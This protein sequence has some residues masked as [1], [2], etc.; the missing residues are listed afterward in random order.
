MV[1]TE[2]KQLCLVVNPEIY[3]K[4]FGF[5]KKENQPSKIRPP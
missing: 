2:A 3:K 1:P 5:W 4:H